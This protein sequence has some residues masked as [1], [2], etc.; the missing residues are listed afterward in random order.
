MNTPQF[1]T[2]PVPTYMSEP[3]HLGSIIAYMLQEHIKGRNMMHLTFNPD[4]KSNCNNQCCKVHGYEMIVTAQDIAACDALAP[5]KWVRLYQS[6][7]M[8]DFAVQ[9]GQDWE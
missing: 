9:A 2:P 6:P 7:H 8:H 1:D 4:R 5:Y 3:F